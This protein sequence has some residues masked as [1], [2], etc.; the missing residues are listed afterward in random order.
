M[1]ALRWV[2]ALLLALAV[3]AGAALLFQRQSAAQ[4]RGEI[5]LL[6]DENRELAQL[7]AENSRLVATQP[8]AAQ[9]EAMRADHAAVRQ[10]R[11]EIEKLKSETDRQARE[12]E[13]ASL[14]PIPAT[15]WKN[16]GR[17][18]TEATIETLLWAAAQHD[19]DALAS[20]MNIDAQLRP[21]VDRFFAVLPDA[22]RAHYGTVE[23]LL[24]DFMTR[25]LPL[26]SMRI[27]SEKTIDDTR[28]VLT[29]HLEGQGN[30][31]DLPVPL[32]HTD[33]GW[34]LAVV[35]DAVQK[36]ANEIGTQLGAAD[37]VK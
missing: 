29:V 20:L 18:T 8:T 2:S 16:A 13:R 12:V 30:A 31:R 6:R 19:P 3:S 34:R 33:D 9:L 35:P 27:V 14:P 26:G 24:A 11:G 25:D 17:A 4:L 37:A 23:R 21:A 36:I 5:A 28:A 7:R 10:L 1:S 32:Q 22:T 15:A